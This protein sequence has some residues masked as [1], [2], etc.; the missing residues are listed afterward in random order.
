MK[1][2]KGE[3]MKKTNEEKRSKFK[4]PGTLV[5]V[6]IFLAV[7]IALYVADWI[8]LSGAWSVR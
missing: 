6:F 3:S 8:L 2:R 5:I 4:A 7:F 1:L